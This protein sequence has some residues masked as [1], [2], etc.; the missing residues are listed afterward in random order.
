MMW[1]EKSPND[2]ASCRECEKTIKKG[3]VRI[4]FIENYYGHTSRRYIHLK[5]L[6]WG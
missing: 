1:K 4:A 5:C 6:K 2:R 3:A